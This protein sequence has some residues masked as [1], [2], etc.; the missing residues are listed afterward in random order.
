MHYT[1]QAR[2][3]ALV[4]TKL[5]LNVVQWDLILDTV[6]GVVD[7]FIRTS[8]LDDTVYVVD[9]ETHYDV[10]E[11][12]SLRNPGVLMVDSIICEFRDRTGWAE[13]LVEPQAYKWFESG[14]ILIA[15]PYV[16]YTPN[17]FNVTYRYTQKEPSSV[18]KYITSG[19]TMIA[20]YYVLQNP[21]NIIT[22]ETILELAALFG[23]DVDK[24]RSIGIEGISVSFDSLS[25]KYLIDEMIKAMK[26]TSKSF[27]D[28]GFET[29]KAGLLRPRF[30]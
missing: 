9:K 2:V 24:I 28:Q 18:P 19:A 6:D 22:P 29:L 27:Q 23:G 5:N 30:D 25:A 1:S 17:I 20:A 10:F 3:E 21:R 4:G 15:S 14:L 12:F 13:H 16:N 11:E 7:A 8:Y 26:N